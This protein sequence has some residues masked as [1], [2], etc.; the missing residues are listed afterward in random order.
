MLEAIINPAKAER[1]PWEMTLVGLFYG[2]LSLLLVNWIFSAD[3]VLSKYS[4]IS[5]LPSQLCFVFLLSITHS[6]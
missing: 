4:G 2:T 1:R 5:S 6:N 3:P